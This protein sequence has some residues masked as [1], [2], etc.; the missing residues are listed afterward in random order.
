MS[1]QTAIILVLLA[2]LIVVRWVVLNTRDISAR[3]RDSYASLLREMASVVAIVYFLF[4]PFVIQTFWIPSGSMIPTL[5]E[6]DRIA[7]N[8]FLYRY[9]PPVRGAVIVFHPPKAAVIP[10]VGE[11][12]PVDLVKRLIGLPG[13]RVR[14]ERD[15]TV[16]VNGSPLAEP[17]VSPDRR[18]TYLFPECLVYGHGSAG[19]VGS[20]P[21]P[22][23]SRLVA[24]IGESGEEFLLEVTR[25]PDDP[26]R[27]EALVPAKSYLVL[28]DNR[29][30]SDDGHRWG[31]VPS[32]AAVGQA[33]FVFWPPARVGLVR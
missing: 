4:R 21:G 25:S 16:Y 20:G 18:G 23:P 9:S 6:Q 15:G 26:S 7:V 1:R 28:G 24:C 31:Y 8:S 19:D 22:I 13:D 5:R 29:A 32:D 3:S 11:G 10:T 14:T 30:Q 12:Q 27:L 17:Y 33:V 2:A